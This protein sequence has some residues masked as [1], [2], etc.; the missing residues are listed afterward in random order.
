[1]NTIVW[2]TQGV[3]SLAFLTHGLLFLFPPAPLR[4]LTKG[5][6]FSAGFLRFICI[7]ESLGAVGLVVP[8]LTGILPWLTPLAAVGLMPIAA[9]AAVFHRSRGEIPPMVI[10]TFL[11]ALA[12]F[13]AYA[14][15]FVIPL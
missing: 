1:M 6:P 10:T 11:F 3:L 15:L 5:M 12:T 7:A 8:G 13:V 14:R 4:K 9:G 2:A